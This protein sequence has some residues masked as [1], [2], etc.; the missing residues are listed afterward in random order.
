MNY[1]FFLD[2]IICVDI[3]PNTIIKSIINVVLIFVTWLFPPGAYISQYQ[4]NA[5]FL[6]LYVIF[7]IGINQNTIIMIPT[8]NIHPA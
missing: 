7:K 6:K 8:S 3:P 4:G 1:N 2:L 5:I